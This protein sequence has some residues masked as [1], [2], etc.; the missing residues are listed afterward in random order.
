MAHRII[1]QVNGASVEGSGDGA[2]LLTDKHGSFLSFGD[3]SDSHVQGYCQFSPNEWE[4]YKTIENISIAPKATTIVNDLTSIERRGDRSSERFIM[5]PKGFLYILDDYA[6]LATV[7]LDF[8]RIY[9]FHDQGR[10]YRVTQ[11]PDGLLVEYK[12]FTDGSLSSLDHTYYLYV[13]GAVNFTL[14]D[15]WIPVEYPYDLRRG[16]TTQRYVY[17]AFDI[18][19]HNRI[20]LA[21]AGSRNPQHAR[22][23]A[24]QV[25]HSAETYRAQAERTWSDTLTNPRVSHNVAIK[26]LDD[27]CVALHDNHAGVFAGLPWFFHLWA[28][29]ELICLGALIAG[30]RY[31][32]VRSILARYMHRFK[33]DGRLPTR[34]PPTTL[35]SADAPGWFCLRAKQFLSKLKE[36]G[37]LEKYYSTDDLKRLYFTVE[38]SIS[39]INRFYLRDH[40]VY[41]GPLETWMDTS[42]GDDAR[43]GACLEVQL[44]HIR[45][46]DLAEWLCSHLGF[47]EA[48]SYRHLRGLMFDAVRQRFRHGRIL[49]DRIDERGPDLVVRPNIFLAHYIYPYIFSSAEWKVFFDE[50]LKELWLHWGGLSTLP[51][52]HPLFVDEYT[53]ENNRSYHHGDSWFFI[54]NIAARQMALVDLHAFRPRI[55]A[56]LKASEQELLFSGFVGHAAEL[57]SACRLESSGCRA[58]AWSLATF[59]DLVDLLDNGMRMHSL[60]ST[61]D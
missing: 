10:V 50:A 37:L 31:D 39:R 17:R 49:A 34:F 59:V 51:R 1:H 8:R 12:K 5:H 45:M 6:G 48:A 11:E 4:M 9:D 30:G 61:V 16:T 13:F 44:L 15:E 36:E 14:R 60:K 18:P 47:D 35:D 27:L 43:Q 53:G 32:L 28:R 25:F 56:I 33:P 24:K 57:S 46:Y 52:S 58:Q 23:N 3:P 41:S 22:Q 40:L 29:D 55:D 54:N 21:F 2:F 26:A 20:R 42:V 19:V 7:D 38:R